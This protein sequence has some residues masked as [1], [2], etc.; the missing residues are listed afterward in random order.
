[1]KLVPVLPLDVLTPAFHRAIRPQTA[2][3]VF[4]RGD[5]DEL[6]RGRLVRGWDVAAP[7]FDYTV[8]GDAASGNSPD[9]I[10]RNKPGGAWLIAPQ[11]A[12]VSSI[13]MPQVKRCPLLTWMNTP[14]G[15]EAWPCSLKPQQRTTPPNSTEG[16]ISNAHV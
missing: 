1:M 15:G 11:H 13:R 14:G 2:R 3:E 16:L 7:A 8:L 12:T 9:E 6:A 10:W 4:S 5:L